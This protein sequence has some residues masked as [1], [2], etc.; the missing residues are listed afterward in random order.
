MRRV[1]LASWR[2]VYLADDE[3]TVVTV[4][5]IRKR[6]PYQYDDLEQLVKDI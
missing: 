4:L 2:V 1:R 6:P 3:R 5:A